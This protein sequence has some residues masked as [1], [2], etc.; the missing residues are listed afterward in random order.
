MSI[1]IKGWGI[2]LLKMILA[3]CVTII[4]LSVFIDIY[5][6]SGIGSETTV[7]VFRDQYLLHSA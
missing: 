6:N 3:G 7:S 4:I 1:R 5:C 2:R